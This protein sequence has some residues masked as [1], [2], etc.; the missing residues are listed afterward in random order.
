MSR[1]KVDLCDLSNTI[2]C[3]ETRSCSMYKCSV[4]D[5]INHLIGQIT[6]MKATSPIEQV[7]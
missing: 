7:S 1:P 5:D 4:S 3:G 2:S 6:Q